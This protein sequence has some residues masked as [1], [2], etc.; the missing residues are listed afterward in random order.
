MYSYIIIH[1]I[2]IYIVYTVNIHIF[3]I[4]IDF[5]LWFR[6]VSQLPAC[7]GPAGP[8]GH[9]RA[10]QGPHGQATVEARQASGWLGVSRNGIA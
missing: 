2:H 3:H 6:R 8:A 5:P 1:I 10:R 7:T 9:G 4:I